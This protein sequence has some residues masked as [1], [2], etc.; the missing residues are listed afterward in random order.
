MG[1]IGNEVLTLADWS[2]RV[3]DSGKVMKI[4]EIL[5]ETNEILDDMLWR[6]GNLPTGHRTTIRTGLPSAYWRMLNMGV[7]KGKSRTRQIDDA[8]GMLEVYSEIDKRLVDL[9]GQGAAVRVSEDKAFLEGM[10][11]QMAT[12]VLYGNVQTDPE[13]IMGFAPRFDDTT[14]EVG[15]NILDGGGRGSVNTSIWLVC[16]GEDTAFGIFPKGSKAGFQMSDKGQVTLEDDSGNQYEGFRTHY[17]WD[18]GLCIRDWRYVV[19]VANIDVAE[20][21]KDAEAGADLIDLLVQATEIPP[22]L[23]GKCAWYCNKTIRSFLRRQITNKSNVHLNIEEVAGKKALTF[24]G[25]PVRRVDKIVSNEETIA[26][27]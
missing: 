25:I 15:A 4:V 12:A 23:K 24:D 16:W 9:N 1:T 3:D 8:C 13:R 11:Q 20:L 14:A 10:S 21:T 18:C 27:A 2:K 19:R 6:E 22:S 7:P 17:A 26:F 5:N